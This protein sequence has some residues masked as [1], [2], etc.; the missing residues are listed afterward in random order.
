MPLRLTDIISIVK[1]NIARKGNPIGIDPAVCSSWAK[2]L[3][4]PRQS[5][6]FIYTSCMYQSIPYLIELVG[7]L[8]KLER[9]PGI[10]TSLGVMMAKAL[11]VA[12][13][14]GKHGARVERFN[15]MVRNIALALK[16]Q[17]INIGY[18]YEEE[19]YSGS[20]LYELGFEDDFAAHAKK[21]FSLFKERGVKSI[22]TIDPH[23]HYVLDKV[24]PRYVDGY[25]VQVTH[26]I[27]ILDPSKL[28]RISRE[29]LDV[30]IHDPC[31]LARFSR[32]VEPQRRLLK[33]AGVGV[34]EPKRSGLR[35]RCCGG[36][37]EALSPTLSRRIGEQRVEELSLLGN[38]IV[39][40]CPICFSN[41]S[42]LAGKYGAEVLDLS[43]LINQ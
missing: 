35:T 7:M 36:P 1:E 16:K 26:Y 13:I 37:I 29:G 27:E 6:V 19:P 39:V 25:D 9:G 11:D 32:I 33:A 40:M 12:S 38:K 17:G 43:E 5:N 22:I 2:D 41:I 42:R 4:I 34:K 31:L 21:V 23:T 30:V 15:N 3:N 18:L 28:G 8:E 14:V 20:L 10:L 24:Y